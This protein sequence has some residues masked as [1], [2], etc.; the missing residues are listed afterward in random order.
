MIAD[1]TVDGLLHTVS[2]YRHAAIS[3]VLCTAF[4]D[5][6]SPCISAPFGGHRRAIS[7]VSVVFVSLLSN[8]ADW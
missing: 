4:G 8:A 7:I 1:M 3:F 5:G 2:L 6:I